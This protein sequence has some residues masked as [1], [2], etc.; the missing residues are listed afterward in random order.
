V[1][2]K[3]IFP[4]KRFL[5]AVFRGELSP[6]FLAAPPAAD[7]ELILER[8]RRQIDAALDTIT[9]RERAIL[10]M[11]FGLGDGYAYTLAEIGYVFRLTRERIRQLQ[12]KAIRNLRRRAE[13]LR[14][15]VYELDD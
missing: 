4:E 9:Y 13:Q 12:N 8:L 1:A 6:E 3:A 15:F 11:R 7:A 5:C 14:N 2:E 10:E